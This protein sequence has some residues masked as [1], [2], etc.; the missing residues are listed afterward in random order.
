MRIVVCMKQVPWTTNVK[1]DPKTGT[2]IRSGIASVINPFDLYA[3]EEALRIKEE[4]DAQI[5]VLSM[6]P[7]QAQ[8]ALKTAL[9]MGC[10]E[11]ILLSDRAFA[12]ADTLATSY[13]LA[14][15]LKKIGDFDLI[16]CGVK[17][18]DGDTAQVGP[19]IAEVL[20]IPH[21]CYVRRI[22]TISRSNIIVQQEM[23]DGYRILEV[24]IPC[25]LT[26]VKEI[27]VPRMPTLKGKLEAIKK[28]VN[29]YTKNDLNGEDS[30]FGLDGSPTQVKRIFEPTHK[31]SGIMISGTPQQIAETLYKELVRLKLWSKE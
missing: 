24:A 11:A 4:K 15:G 16:I 26:V 28:P 8:Y 23:D 22:R 21:V 17:T 1:T 9:A 6:G 20:D 14:Q 19:G 3:I 10:D 13:T 30:R 29:I 7:P 31:N 25:L 5:T 18:V 27:N 2:L 12:G